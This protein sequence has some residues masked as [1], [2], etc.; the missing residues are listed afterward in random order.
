MPSSLIGIG[1]IKNYS[2]VYTVVL[3]LIVEKETDKGECLMARIFLQTFN[4]ICMI[5]H[6]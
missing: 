3:L 5:I 1:L 4:G 2:I 6:N